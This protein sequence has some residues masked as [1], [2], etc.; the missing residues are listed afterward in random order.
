MVEI[1]KM[2]EEL[3]RMERDGGDNAVTAVEGNSNKSMTEF[4]N[5]F[6]G[7]FTNKLTSPGDIVEAYKR[8]RDLPAMGT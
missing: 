1:E 2:V 7:T 5:S 6:R 4:V 8:C 3:K